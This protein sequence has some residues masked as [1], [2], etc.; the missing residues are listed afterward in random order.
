[1]SKSNK[2]KNKHSYPTVV[3]KKKGKS[4]M[5]TI[6]VIFIGI[7]YLIFYSVKKTPNNP[8]AHPKSSQQTTNTPPAPRFTNIWIQR[9][10]SVDELFHYVYTPC[11]EGA[12]GAIGDAYLYAATKD[13]ALLQFHL[14]DHDLKKMCAGTW[15]DDRAWVALAEFTWWDFTGRTNRLLVEDAK[16]RY[17]SARQEGRLSNY[18]GFWAWYNWP[19]T[20]KTRERIFTNSATNQMAS[21][22]CWLYIATGERSFLDDALLIWNG[23]KK[24]PGVEKRLYQGNGVWQGRHGVVAFGKELGWEGV[25]YCTLAS[26]LYRIT[27][28]PKYKQIAVATVQR[29]MN[30]ENGWVDAQYFYQTHMDGNG[31]FVNFLFDAYAIAPDELN[32]IPGKVEKMLDH[33]WTNNEGSASVILHR[34]SDHGIRNGWNSD[35]GEQGYNVDEVGTVHAQGEAARAFGVFTYYNNKPAKQ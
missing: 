9:A 1:M 11:W 2:K 4:I 23:D 33:V 20:S 13:S 12:Y 32:D 29:V 5:F 25:E 18:E 34:E 10:Y 35:G 27:K 21:V 22:A 3:E 30:P 17:L 7:I 8:I 26:L 6:A 14:I 28:E 31:A 15:V 24:F 16:Q 19:P